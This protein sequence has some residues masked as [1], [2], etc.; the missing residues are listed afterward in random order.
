VLIVSP[1]SDT[2]SFS[3]AALPAI[4]LGD[5]LRRSL[6][7]TLLLP[8]SPQRRQRTTTTLPAFTPGGAAAN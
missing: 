3:V 5:W 6:A 1:T 2:A 7:I 4:L 8:H